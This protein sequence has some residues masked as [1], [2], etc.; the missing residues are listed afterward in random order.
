[1]TAVA[2]F[3]DGADTMLGEHVSTQH[4]IDSYY[5]EEFGSGW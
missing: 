4:E 1:M 5:A 3:L 2:N